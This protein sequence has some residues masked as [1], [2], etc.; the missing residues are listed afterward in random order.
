M[1]LFKKLLGG[2]RKDRSAAEAAPQLARELESLVAEAERLVAAGRHEEALHVAEQGLKRFPAAARLRSVVR[3][4]RR[5]GANK[6]LVELKRVLDERKDERA[7]KE[8]ISL[9][10]DLNNKDQALEVATG[11][12]EEF[13]QQPDANILMGEVFLARYFGELFAR[14]AWS[15]IEHFERALELNP[16][17]IRGHVLLA[18][19]YYA[20]GAPRGAAG[21]IGVVLELDPNNQRLAEFREKLLEVAGPEG[22]E[23]VEFLLDYA[24]DHQEVPNDPADFPGGKR[25][26]L[27]N[28]GGAL[29]PKLFAA[30]AAGIGR[31]LRIEQLAAIG[32][33]G[34][35]LAVAGE[36]KESFV[37]LAC[38]LDASS[39]RAGRHM[40]FGTMRRFMVEGKFGRMVLVPAGN[41][42]VAARAP[43][44]VSTE[45]IAEGLEMVVTASRAENG[46]EEA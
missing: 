24:Q 32:T 33:G 22:E 1:K 21:E 38:R 40:N 36:N 25:F 14:D 23:D 20:I 19:L 26:S 43:R 31:R 5:A 30:A 41:C 8:L 18:L 34:R 17:T 4:V 46:E 3:Y 13:P 7:Y 45:R 29:S 11:Y 28:G 15:A 35:P 27:E 9:H 12:L 42:A 6:R 39:R 44:S 37:K 10:L 16:S 2:G